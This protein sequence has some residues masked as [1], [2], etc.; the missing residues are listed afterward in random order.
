MARVA[1]GARR[2]ILSSSS[3]GRGVGH[4]DWLPFLDTYRTMCLAPEPEFRRLL[5]EARELPIA[6]SESIEAAL[7]P[8]VG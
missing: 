1:R 3:T 2:S 8:L 5:E 4:L 7:T 6:A